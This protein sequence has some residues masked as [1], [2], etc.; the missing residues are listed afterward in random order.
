MTIIKWIFA[1]I[2]CLPLAVRGQVNDPSRALKVLP[3]PKEVHMAAGKMVIKPATT[4][5]ISNA[6][7]RTAAEMLQT[8]IHDRTGLKL[9]IELVTAAPRTAG[10]ISLERLTDRGL[11]SYLELQGV[12]ADELGNAA[13]DKQGYVIRST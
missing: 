13:L 3:A 4:I 8:E 11:R 5:L 12:K 9:S 7:D 2:L 1:G 6:Q 10:H